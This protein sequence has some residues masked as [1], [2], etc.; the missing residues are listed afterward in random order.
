MKEIRPTPQKKNE[1]VTKPA[2][3]PHPPFIRTTGIFEFWGN[4]KS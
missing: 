2:A 3:K 4:S 1:I